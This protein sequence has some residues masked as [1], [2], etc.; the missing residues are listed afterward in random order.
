VRFPRHRAWIASLLV[1]I[2]VVAWA[3]F[4]WTGRAERRLAEAERCLGSGDFKV[5]PSWL[6]LPEVTARTRDRA[7]LIRARA[8]LARGRPAEAVKPLDAIGQGSPSAVDA[9]FWKGRT[10][11]VVGQFL[12]AIDWLRSVVARRPDDA[13]AHRWLAVASYELG[14]SKS[15]LV[16]LRE[17]VRLVPGDERAWR[18][19]ALLLKEGAEP[20]QAMEAYLTTLRLDP[21]QPQARLELAEVLTTMGQYDEAGRHL[22]ACSGGVPEGDR[23]DLI[24]K[25]LRARGD[26]EALPA[27]LDRALAQHPNHVGLLQHRAQ[28]ATAEGR[29]EEA[30]T[31]LDRALA[32]DP[33]HASS[34]YQRGLLR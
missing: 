34:Y 31:L 24:A 30:I 6:V 19:I 2:L 15:T 12:R 9:A 4:W 20:E 27:M 3:Y 25:C 13:E 22:E 28:V 26:G 5:L 14:D 18:T 16:E 21:A 29:T 1:V 10:L 32:V 8:A 11:L 7:L 33:F 23:L 17:V